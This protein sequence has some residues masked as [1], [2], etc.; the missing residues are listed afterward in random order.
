MMQSQQY[1]LNKQDWIKWAKSGL[2]WLI[3]VFSLYVTQVIG[4]LNVPNHILS[5][6]DLLPTNLTLGGGVLYI[7]ERIFDILRRW[8]AGN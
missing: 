5:I 4:T 3:P 6:K 2:I 1:A 7:Y 8:K